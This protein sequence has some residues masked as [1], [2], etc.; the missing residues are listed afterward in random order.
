LELVKEGK[1]E[2]QQ[3]DTFAPIQLRTKRPE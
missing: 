1:L 3:S 2:I